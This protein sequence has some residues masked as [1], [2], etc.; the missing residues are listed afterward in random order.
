MS[1]ERELLIE[2]AVRGLVPDQHT[3]VRAEFRD[4]VV[5]LLGRVDYRSA[6][7]GIGRLVRAVPGVVE[8]R[9]RM[10]YRWDDGPGQRLRTGASA[11]S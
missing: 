11:R 1:A 3:L 5:L 8:V 10:S 9:N 4:G 7:P 6:L 2:R